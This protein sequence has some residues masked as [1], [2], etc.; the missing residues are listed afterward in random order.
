MTL[1]VGSVARYPCHQSAVSWSVTTMYVSSSNESSDSSFA[2][3]DHKA[4]AN[5]PP[6][7]RATSKQ[8][9]RERRVRRERVREEREG[10]G[11]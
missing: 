11:G 7:G 1:Q 3:Y 8:R 2:S 6:G 9:H 5:I 10:K 4:I